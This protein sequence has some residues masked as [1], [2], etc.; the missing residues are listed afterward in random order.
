MALAGAVGAIASAFLP[1]PPGTERSIV[2]IGTIACI[3]G[4]GVG[5]ILSGMKPGFLV[6]LVLAGVVVAVVASVGFFEVA[7]GRPGLE[8]T[9]LLYGLTAGIFLGVGLLI[10][11]VG[12]KL[13]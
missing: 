10:E 13:A 2:L 11:V 12:V 8:A 7:T 9:R 4:A 3:G 5:V 6:L 1:A